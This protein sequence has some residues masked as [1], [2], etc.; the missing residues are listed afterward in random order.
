MGRCAVSAKQGQG[1]HGGMMHCN[2]GVKEGGIG[3]G[4]DCSSS[5]GTHTSIDDGGCHRPMVATEP[6]SQLLSTQQ[7]KN[8]LGNS[9][10]LLKLEKVIIN[11]VY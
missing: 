1:H 4:G 6:H 7:S 10:L 3:A 9:L 5:M 2:S 11:Y 8:I